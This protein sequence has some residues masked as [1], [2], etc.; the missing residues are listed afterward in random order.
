M[1]KIIVAITLFLALSLFGCAGAEVSRTVIEKKHQPAYYET[2]SDESYRY[3]LW[4]G[5]MQLVPIVKTRLAPEEWFVVYEITY[6]SG[7]TYTVATEVTQPEWDAIT[8]GST[9]N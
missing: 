8:I 9:I 7:A 2:Y 4:T 3:N 1:K 6:E 5:Q